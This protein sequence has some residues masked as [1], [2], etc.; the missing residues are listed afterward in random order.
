MSTEKAHKRR[1]EEMEIVNLCVPD[2]QGVDEKHHGEEE[3]WERL[4]QKILEG[5]RMLQ[6]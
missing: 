6:W 2:W 1:V 5:E 4:F 3:C